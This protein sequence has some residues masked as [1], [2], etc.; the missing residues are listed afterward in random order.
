VP[1]FAGDPVH[2]NSQTNAAVANQGKTEFLFAH[3]ID[4]AATMASGKPQTSNHA[5]VC[6]ET[7]VSFGM[8]LQFPLQYCFESKMREAASRAWG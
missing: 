3:A 5:G 7:G 6:V 2:V 1:D 4:V 8:I